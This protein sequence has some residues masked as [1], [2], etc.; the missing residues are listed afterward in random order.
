MSRPLISPWKSWRLVVLIE[1]IHVIFDFHFFQQKKYTA[2]LS[3]SRIKRNRD[4]SA[5]SIDS[6]ESLSCKAGS[7]HELARE[8]SKLAGLYGERSADVAQQLEVPGKVRSLRSAPCPQGGH[9][10]FRARYTTRQGGHSCRG[11][12]KCV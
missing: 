5:Q 6:S 7:V 9:N 1:M 12:K 10:I 4:G 2:G 8:R 11:H 3:A